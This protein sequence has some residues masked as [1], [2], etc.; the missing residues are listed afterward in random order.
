MQLQQSHLEILDLETGAQIVVEVRAHHSCPR[1]RA[2][3]SVTLTLSVD[4]SLSS[5]TILVGA[6]ARHS[7]SCSH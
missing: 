1:A 5:R 6:R 3:C 4:R 2:R 7:L